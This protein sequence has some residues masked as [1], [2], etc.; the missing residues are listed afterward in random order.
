[1]DD[2]TV[3]F[4]LLL[5]SLAFGLGYFTRTIAHPS[6]PLFNS[7]VDI[8]KI[9]E[10]VQTDDWGEMFAGMLGL[11][12]KMPRKLEWKVKDL[13]KE[14]IHEVETHIT[15][16]RRRLKWQKLVTSTLVVSFFTS[17]LVLLCFARLSFTELEHTIWWVMC[18]I[19]GAGALFTTAVVVAKQIKIRELSNLTKADGAMQRQLSAGLLSD[20]HDGGSVHG[21][22]ERQLSH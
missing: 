21:A 13:I 15:G 3:L 8:M 17:L 7:L 18:A 1:M 16:M 10:G 19:S 12:A 20:T 14:E 2:L 22:L 4:I 5:C 11:R 9:D 6:H